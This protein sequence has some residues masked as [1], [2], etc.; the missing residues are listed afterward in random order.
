LLV[1]LAPRAAVAGRLVAAA[2]MDPAGATLTLRSAADELVGSTVG[3]D[4]AF[5]FAAKV[6]PGWATLAAPAGRFAFAESGASVLQ[7]R[8][9]EGGDRQLDLEVVAPTLLAGRVVDER[10]VPLA[11]ATLSVVQT[12]VVRERL[13]QAGTAL[14]ERNLA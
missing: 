9:G 6:T 11:G 7:V 4:G 3:A 10:G 5:Q 13:L 14:W 12:D 2:G 8:I 1:E